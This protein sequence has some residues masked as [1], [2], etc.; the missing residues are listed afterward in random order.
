MNEKNNTIPTPKTPTPRKGAKSIKQK[1]VEKR[2]APSKQRIV[3]PLPTPPS[4]QNK[5][6]PKQKPYLLLIIAIIV[7]GVLFWTQKD[8]ILKNTPTDTKEQ[9][10]INQGDDTL[11]V[12]KDITTQGEISAA[13]NSKAKYTHL[14]KS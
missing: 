13:K 5:K 7:I 10:V 9:L 12:G 2:K 4:R 8:T 11:F 1:T 3:A 14:I 6:Q